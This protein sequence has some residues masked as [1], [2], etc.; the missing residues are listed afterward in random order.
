MSVS[1]WPKWRFDAASARSVAVHGNRVVLPAAA[2]IFE[3]GA[4]DVTAPDVFRALRGE[5]AP[6]KALDALVR[7]A[8]MGAL[9]EMPYPGR[10]HPR[11]F[12]RQTSAYW[13]FVREELLALPGP[14]EVPNG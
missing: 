9:A 5:V 12:S 13:S 4:T 11:R 6:N 10:P 1:E 3:S 14:S 7:L 2:W 8:Q